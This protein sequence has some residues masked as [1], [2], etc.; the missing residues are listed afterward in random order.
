[1]SGMRWRKAARGGRAPAARRARRGFTLIE[2]MVAM[3]ILA[4]GLLA[5]LVMQIY[6]LQFGRSGLHTTRAGVLAQDRME[7]LQRLPWSDPQLTATAGFTAP[8][9]IPNPDADGQSYNLARRVSD[10]AP[11]L[12]A[13]DVRVTWSEPNRPNRVH[14]ISSIRHD[15]PGTP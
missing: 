5:M 11:N 9:A 2:V 10:L 3:G 8:A 12:K 6:A 13:I 15:D 7:L 14:T 1:M 4:F